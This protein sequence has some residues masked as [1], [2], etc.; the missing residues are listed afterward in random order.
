M[1]TGLKLV[2]PFNSM[3][4]RQDYQPGQGQQPE[5]DDVS[6]E[7]I[8]AAL[9]G[10]APQQQQEQQQQQRGIPPPSSAQINS[11]A[12]QPPPPTP[13]LFQ[14]VKLRGLPFSATKQNVKAFLV[15]GG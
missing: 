9:A 11:S 7:M 2:K 1:A 14:G 3:P 6:W 12:I 10:A 8:A 13:E 4:S 15:S 5:E